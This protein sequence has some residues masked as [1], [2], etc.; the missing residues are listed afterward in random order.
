MTEDVAIRPASLLDAERLAALHLQVWREA[1]AGLMP[2]EVLAHRE[3]EPEL[4]RV[5]R[6]VGRVRSNQIL[7]ADDG[8]LVVGWAEVGPSRDADLAG[9]ELYSIYLAAS[10]YSTGL[11]HRLLDAV[12]GERPAHVWVLR[13]N[14]RAERFYQRHGF[15][16]D[17]S[18]VVD[19]L[20]LSDLR[21]RRG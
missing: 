7:V 6:W 12:L 17:G 8:G 15:A 20:G 2:D 11:G 18:E 9:E 10:H 1:Y 19:E 4:A 21:M 5:T 16:Y 3:A 13:G 14:E